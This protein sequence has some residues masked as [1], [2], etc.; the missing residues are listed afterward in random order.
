MTRFRLLLKRERTRVSEERTRLKVQ[1]REVAPPPRD[2]PDALAST[3]FNPPL[4]ECPP[5]AHAT[6]EWAKF[7]L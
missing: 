1:Q 6:T 5:G 2:N 3:F 4:W 7:G